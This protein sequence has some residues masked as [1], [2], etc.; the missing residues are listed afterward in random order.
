MVAPRDPTE[1]ALVVQAIT[2]GVGG[3]CE[4][5]E[6]AA[7]RFRSAPPLPGLTPEGVKDDLVAYV[8]G[9]ANRVVQVIEKRSEYN[10]RRFYYKVILPMHGLRHGLFVEIVLDDEDPELPTVRIVDAHEQTR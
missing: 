8:Q 4:W 10:D 9:G 2:C 3:C 6:K 5:D 7:K 1:H